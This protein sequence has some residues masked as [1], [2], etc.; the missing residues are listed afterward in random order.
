M[1]TRTPPIA[2][3][4]IKLENILIA[5]DGSLRLCDFGSCSTRSG[6]IRS[7]AERVDEQDVIDRFTTRVYRAPEMVDLYSGVAID[8]RVDVWALGCLLYSLCFKRHPFDDDGS[9]AVISARYVM[10]TWR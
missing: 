2:H 8:H 9:L 7:K 5:S 6:P 4:D 1:H 3:R 10:G